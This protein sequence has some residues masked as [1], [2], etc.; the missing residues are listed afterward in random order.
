MKKSRECILTNNTI[1]HINGSSCLDGVVGTEQ[2]PNADITSNAHTNWYLKSGT[3]K[4]Y[5]GNQ[6]VVAFQTG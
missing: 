2:V 6:N 1:A 5:K 3:K 4:L